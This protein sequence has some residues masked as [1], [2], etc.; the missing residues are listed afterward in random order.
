MAKPQQDREPLSVNQSTVQELEISDF[1]QDFD[2]VDQASMESFPA[3]D[4]PSWI[5]RE[6]KATQP[7]APA[8][9]PARS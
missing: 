3:S 9:V 1:P 5:A 8:S 7:N 6:P 4:P 2:I